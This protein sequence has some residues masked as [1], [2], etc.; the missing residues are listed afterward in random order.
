M[1]VVWCTQQHV[2]LDAALAEMHA[3]MT[4]STKVFRAIVKGEQLLAMQDCTLVQADD[5]PTME[6]AFLLE[7]QQREVG[8]GRQEEGLAP[9][10][11]AKESVEQ[12][13]EQTKEEVVQNEQVGHQRVSG[14]DLAVHDAFT[15]A[16]PAVVTARNWSGALASSGTFV[17]CFRPAYSP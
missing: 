9:E 2:E 14:V 4:E 8:E 12:V 10:E 16:S 11:T 5:I 3:E 1:I 17:N 6:A 15:A 13:V 7:S